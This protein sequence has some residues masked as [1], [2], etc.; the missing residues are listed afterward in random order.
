MTE[1]KK[2]VIVGGG[3]GGVATAMEL[4]KLIG[5][6]ADVEII[7]I[8]KTETT[9]HNIAT[10]RALVE[11]AFAERLFVPY[12]NVFAKSK[13]SKIVNG[14]VKTIETN[15]V[16]LEGGSTISFDHLVIATGSAYPAPFKVPTTTKS[17]GIEAVKTV[18]T[19]IKSASNI[20]IVGG[21]PVG[22]ELAGEIAVDHPIKKVTVVQAA[23]TL[24]VGP[25]S[26]KF[27]SRV[28]SG[29]K[30]RNVNVILNERITN[31]DTLFPDPTQ[32]GYHEGQTTLTTSTNRTIE[33][34]LVFLATGTATFNS[35]P[36]SSLGAEVIDAKSQIKTLPTLQL[37]SHPHI[38]ALGDVSSTTEG[39][40]LSFIAGMQ[41]P[42]VAQNIVSLLSSPQKPKLKEFSPP[43]MT[44][45]L[46]TLGRTGG[47]AQ[48]GVVLGDWFAR[49]LKSGDLLTK[50]RW[51]DL[52]VADQYKW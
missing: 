4:D 13:T 10:P 48:M 43:G 9:F 40:K 17:A 44:V 47:V 46:V 39:K 41:A 25:Y 29:L 32:K 30:S 34:D 24:M 36:A 1:T 35:A 18:A 16:K 37:P 14:T 49:M 15:L 38:F 12:T 45:G 31:L 7:L 52:K 51:G 42:V 33:A 5:S 28:L 3:Y 20:V 19:A 22:V 11:P 27:K 2:I 23:P 6:R 8:T 26:D 21:G 50:R